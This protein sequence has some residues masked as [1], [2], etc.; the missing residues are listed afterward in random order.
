MA[1]VKI[2]KYTLNGKRKQKQVSV[3]ERAVK[4]ELATKK[5]TKKGEEYI[6]KVSYLPS[7]KMSV[8]KRL[9]DVSV[10]KGAEDLRLM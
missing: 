2:L 6:V 8:K 1:K 4:V 3:P 9:K 7:R 10:P 5:P